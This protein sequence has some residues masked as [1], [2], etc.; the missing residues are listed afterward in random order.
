ML[1]IVKWALRAFAGLSGLKINFTKSELIALNISSVFASN[2]AIQL[3]CKLSSLPMKY[4]GLSLHW[5]KPSRREWKYLIDKISKKLPTWKYK[6]LSIGGHLV[7]LNSVLSTIPLYYFTLFKILI[8]VI[9]KIDPIWKRFLWSGPEIL[10][11]KCHLVKWAIVCCPKDVGGWGVL[12]LEHMNVVFLFKCF[13]KYKYINEDGLWQSIICFKNT[14]A[15]AS[16]F[17]AF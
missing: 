9:H 6:L 11:K 1:E 2:S 17:S 5:K 10:K 14:N 16:N 3:N 4:L 15:S 13:W 8:W 12:N 7:L